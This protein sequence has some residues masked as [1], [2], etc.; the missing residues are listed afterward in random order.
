[1]STPETGWIF[2][3]IRGEKVQKYANSYK[4]VTINRLIM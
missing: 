2:M 3:I 1:M 4:M